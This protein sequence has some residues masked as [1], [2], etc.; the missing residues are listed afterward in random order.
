MPVDYSKF[1]HIG[2]S[3]DEE[4]EKKPKQAQWVPPKQE[5]RKT[6]PPKPTSAK[7]DPRI[8]NAAATRRAAESLESTGLEEKL[9][10]VNLGAEAGNSTHAASNHSDGSQLARVADE[11]EKLMPQSQSTLNSSSTPKTPNDVKRLCVKAD[12]KTKIHTTNPDGSE[13]VEEFEERTDKLLMRKTRAPTFLGGE[14][15]WVYEV[16]QS[17]EARFDPL[18]DMIV[19]SPSNPICTRK[20][21]ATHFQWR[22]RNC[23]FPTDVYGVSIDHGKQQIVVRTSNKKYYKRIDVLDLKRTELKLDDTALTWKHQHNT[24]IISYTKPKKVLEYEKNVLTLADKSAVQ[25]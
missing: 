2:D 14:G 15:E 7:R 18:A 10:R 9:R 17:N 19:Q 3:S 24:L 11:L 23:A 21:T 6:D 12:G 20:D 16:G 13:M 8:R 1:D 22:I 4:E 25:L 5:P